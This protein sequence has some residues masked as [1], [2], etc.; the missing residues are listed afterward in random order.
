MSMKFRFVLWSAAAGAAA[1]GSVFAQE[2]IPT[3]G[4]S[5]TGAAPHARVERAI[6]PA[7]PS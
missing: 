5:P 6:A 2:A 3:A 4:G 7:R 1:A